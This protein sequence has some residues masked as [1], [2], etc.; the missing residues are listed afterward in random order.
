MGSAHKSSWVSSG[1]GSQV[2]PTAASVPRVG[3]RSS[4]WRYVS[5]SSPPQWHSAES[6]NPGGTLGDR[7]SFTGGKATSPSLPLCT[8]TS[9]LTQDINRTRLAGLVGD[10]IG[11]MC[12]KHFDG[13]RRDIPDGLEISSCASNA[14]DM[15]SRTSQGTKIPRA[16][17]GQKTKSKTM[18]NTQ[19]YR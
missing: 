10:L 7:T 1:L 4:G 15:G 3:L 11:V 6:Q 8:S 14:G 5:L 2:P 19:N 9:I 13:T 12:T 18:T 16:M 17:C